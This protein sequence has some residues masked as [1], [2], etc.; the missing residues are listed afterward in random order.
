MSHNYPYRQAPADPR[1]DPRTYSSAGG[2]EVYR[3]PPESFPS[4]SRS[5]AASVSPQDGVLGLLSSCGLEP[6]DLAALAKLPEDML[7]VDSLPVLIN[8][9]KSKKG[10]AK[11]SVPTPL[12]PPPPSSSHSF[13]SSHRPSSSSSL[14]WDKL[15]R[16]P[17]QYP[18]H[19]IPSSAPLPDTH[20]D[21]WG[22]PG[23]VRSSS[24]R[25]V[26]DTDLRPRLSEY[27]KAA[28]SCSAVELKRSHPSRFSDP[29][30][31]DY[32]SV[33][34]PDERRRRSGSAGGREP[35][36]PVPSK[37]QGLDFHG[38]MP[39]VYPY[40]CS[41]CDITV[42]S[43][44]VSSPGRLQVSG[45]ELGWGGFWWEATSARGSEVASLPVCLPG[46]ARTHQREHS[47]RRTAQAAAAVSL[48]QQHI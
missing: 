25:P 9:I 46:L 28:S 45:G 19:M 3:R 4:S 36:G 5:S 29:G 34:P 24:V 12:P 30:S 48:T 44:K 31:A 20:S 7:T 15:R 8:Q 33:P 10:A 42:L 16:Q 37:Q 18:L 35:E 47:C 23:A 39:P 40:S 6:A 11:P 1:S 2:A 41:L 38:S 21:P 13:S 32:R 17:V 26:Q 27:G 22:S 14:D 43:E